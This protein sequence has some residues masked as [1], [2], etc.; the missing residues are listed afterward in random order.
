M[1]R[2]ARRYPT[3]KTKKSPA[4]PKCRRA[5][6]WN[7]PELEGVGDR[8]EGAAEVCADGSHHRHGCDGNQRGDQTI[9]NRSRSVLVLKES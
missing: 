5:L 1:C 2:Q 4:A 7:N 9:L 8:I 3:L 6:F